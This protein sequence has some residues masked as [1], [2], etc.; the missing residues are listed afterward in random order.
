MLRSRN[1]SFFPRFPFLRTLVWTLAL[2][3][4]SAHIRGVDSAAGAGSLEGF[5]RADM[6]TEEDPAT[7]FFE[8][9]KNGEGAL[10]SSFSAPMFGD[11]YLGT[12]LPP[13]KIEGE[14]IKLGLFSGVWDS[15]SEGFRGRF[16]FFGPSVEVLLKRAD[17]I[18]APVL[19]ETPS[20]APKPAWR[21]DA[22]APVWSSPL[23]HGERLYIGTDDGA[24]YALDAKTGA[25]RWCIRTG[26]LIRSRAV[27]AAGKIVFVSDDG[28]LR[29]VAP[30]DG[31]EAWRLDL[32][33]GGNKR[34]LPRL[35]SE[36]DWDYAQSSPLVV[37]DTLFIGDANGVIH[38]LASEDGTE[39][40]AFPTGAPIRGGLAEKEGSLAAANWA[41]KVF[42][43]ETDK[44][45]PLWVFDAKGSVISTPA[46]ARENV[47]VGSRYSYLWSIDRKTGAVAWQRNYWWS[48]IE[49]SASLDESGEALY[50]GSSDGR[51]VQ[52]LAPGDGR[53]L[54]RTRCA[55]YPWS[56]PLVTNRLVFQGTV[57]CELDADKN[58]YLYALAR[59]TGRILAK[60]AIGPREGEAF[61]GVY[62]RPELRADLLF[63]GALDGC[64][65]A[66]PVENISPS[67]KAR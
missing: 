47:V 24:F 10:Q 33:T 16:S 41:G 61:H 40:W 18:D 57:S 12:P 23:V 20:T 1:P 53:L 44:G 42:L 43:L 66:L 26:G 30:A 17:R 36:S 38:A 37:G 67:D 19:D 39:R 65:Y 49:S 5:W 22:G 35:D 54:W 62:G 21:F 48:W 27:V 60:V 34:D 6:G 3:S 4:F 64:V 45:R 15:R 14:S 32:K 9:K 25:K 59:D 11:R 56:T 31:T 46:F 13:P 28:I 2:F 7:V 29:A 58:G 52:A 50:I 51:F 8:L 63:F 55:G